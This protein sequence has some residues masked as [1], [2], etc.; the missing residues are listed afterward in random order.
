MAPDARPAWKKGGI[1]LTE[2]S[3][4]PKPM[5]PSKWAAT[6][7]IPGSFTASA[8]WRFGTVTEPTVTVSCDVKPESDPEPYRMANAVPFLA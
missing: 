7:A 8:N 1:P 4:K 2:M 6:N 5:M 3:G